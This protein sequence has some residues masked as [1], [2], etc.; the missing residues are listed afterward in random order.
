[1]RYK[2]L[3]VDL[4]SPTGRILARNSSGG[5]YL[6]GNRVDTEDAILLLA[7]AVEDLGYFCQVAKDVLDE[8]TFEDV[9]YVYAYDGEE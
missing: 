1:M 5:W 3:S 2:T 7:D 4:R 8:D 9:M 6:D